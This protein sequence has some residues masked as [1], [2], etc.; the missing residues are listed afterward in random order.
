MK[1]VAATARAPAAA[2]VQHHI[3]RPIGPEFAADQ[4][5]NF[6]Y[7]PDMLQVDDCYHSELLALCPKAPEA[8]VQHLIGFWGSLQQPAY[9]LQ[10]HTV[11][12]HVDTFSHNQSGVA[13]QDESRR[14]ETA[15]GTPP[16]A[17]AATK[18]GDTVEEWLQGVFAGD[19]QGQLA[20]CV[21]EMDMLR[22]F[23]LGKGNTFG[24]TPRQQPPGYIPSLQYPGAGGSRYERSCQAF[25]ATVHRCCLCVVRCTCHSN[26]LH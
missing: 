17:E 20:R 23:L 6:L 21:F 11:I 16:A 5:P 9:C 18:S 1:I 22:R 4:L 12:F 3:W 26:L 25:P 19:H 14:S 7:S 15:T 24:G 2:T 8:R 13:Y 10:G